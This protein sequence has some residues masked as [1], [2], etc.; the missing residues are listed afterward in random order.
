MS[1]H[2]RQQAVCT[3][4]PADWWFSKIVTVR[5][6]ENSDRQTNRQSDKQTDSET[7]SQ[8]NRQSDEQADSQ[9]NRQTVRRTDSQTNRQTVRQTVRQ[10]SVRQTDRQSERQ[11]RETDR[12]TDS[13]VGRQAGI[14]KVIDGFLIQYILR[15]TIWYSHRIK[16]NM[17]Y[18]TPFLFVVRSRTHFGQLCWP[19]S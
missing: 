16:T 4:L 13:Q 3:K 17:L 1:W 19:P 12:Q 11:S 7:D 8:T 10:Q 14:A 2:C 9:T 18:N 15:V 6:Q 5:F